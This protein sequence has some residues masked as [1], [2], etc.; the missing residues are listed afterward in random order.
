MWPDADI[1]SRPNFPKVAQNVAKAVFTWNWMFFKIVQKSLYIW[2]IFVITIFTQNFKKSPNLVTLR[3][4]RFNYDVSSVKKDTFIVLVLG[5]FLTSC[6]PGKKI[7]EKPSQMDYLLNGTAK[8]LNRA[9]ALRSLKGLIN[10]HRTFSF[11][12]QNVFRPPKLE[13]ILRK[14][15]STY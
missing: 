9:K 14:M 11:W 3:P 12:D 1:K 5:G 4:Q 10:S 15:T 2:A 13:T 6:L 7:L 8:S